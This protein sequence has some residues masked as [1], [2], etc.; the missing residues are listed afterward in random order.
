MTERLY[1]P[2]VLGPTKG[3]IHP[4]KL[5]P[6]AKRALAIALLVLIL[7]LLVPPVAMGGMQPCPACPPA[8]GV[9]GCGLCFVG[10][11]GLLLLLRPRGRLTL[12]G[13]RIAVPFLLRADGLDRPPQT[14]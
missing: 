6:M 8:H 5:A 10:L 4:G 12:E 13:R 1:A 7:L 11:A 9:D 3:Y 2:V 14:R